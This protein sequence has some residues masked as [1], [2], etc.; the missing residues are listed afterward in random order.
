MSSE[1]R[2]PLSIVSRQMITWLLI[3]M[4]VYVFIYLIFPKWIGKTP[5]TP[6]AQILAKSYWF[7]VGGLL[8]FFL[9]VAFVLVDSRRVPAT[10]FKLFSMI[11]SSVM[12][13]TLAVFLTGGFIDSPFSGAVALYIGFFFVMLRRRVYPL[14]NAFFMLLTILLLLFPYFHLWKQSHDMYIVQWDPAPLVTWGR[15]AMNIFLLIAAAR[16]GARVSDAV[17]SFPREP[18]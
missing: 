11:L 7:H 6:N 12:L 1:D 13:L 17:S 2:N 15:L 10:T 5:Y 14:F 3:V 9:T 18:L 16:V 8:F 4:A